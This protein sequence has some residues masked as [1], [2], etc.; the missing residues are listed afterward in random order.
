MFEQSFLDKEHQMVLNYFIK[1]LNY[2]SHAIE[3]LWTYDDVLM[4]IKN[5]INLKN[6]IILNDKI[7]IYSP[8][9]QGSF[10]KKTVFLFKNHKLYSIVH[11]KQKKFNIVMDPWNKPKKILYNSIQSESN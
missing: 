2:G 8:L 9:G 5:Y 6:I 3:T 1:K 11:Q 4:V 10:N 7:I